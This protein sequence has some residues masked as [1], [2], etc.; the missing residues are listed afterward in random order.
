MKI[1]K[2]V[3][4]ILTIV[5]VLLTFCGCGNLKQEETGSTEYEETGLNYR[6]DDEVTTEETETEPRLSATC[7]RI[8]SKGEDDNGD[9]YE[10]V[11]SQEETATSVAVK[12]G[13]IK[14]NKWLVPLTADHPY[15]DK[16]T[17]KLWYYETFNYSP[18]YTTCNITSSYKLSYKYIGS[19]C[20]FHD[21]C[22]YNSNTGAIYEDSCDITAKHFYDNENLM[23]LR[24]GTGDRPVKILDLSTFEVKTIMDKSDFGIAAAPSEGLFCVRRSTVV[25]NQYKYYFYDLNGNQVID[26]SKYRFYEFDGQEKAPKGE[27]KFIDGK[28]SFTVLNDAGTKF[29]VTIDKTGKVL[30]EEKYV[31]T[32]EN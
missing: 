4:A 27:R 20:F 12:I 10:L 29:K 1:R 3:S 23:I 26:L 17:G 7:D 13:V 11:A 28:C 18:H 6:E 14:N 32:T 31:P 2:L 8:L 22:F 24:I 15:I 16:D 21:G 30:S 19:G 9:Y 25:Y 5:M